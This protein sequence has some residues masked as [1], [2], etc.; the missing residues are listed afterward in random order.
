MNKTEEQVEFN[1]TISKDDRVYNTS[2]YE[3]NEVDLN[4][5]SSQDND[6]DAESED[7]Q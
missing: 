4:S 7:E 1:V 2:S 5:T 3:L 6:D